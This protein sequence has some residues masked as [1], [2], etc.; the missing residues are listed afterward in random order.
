[1]HSTCLQPAAVHAGTFSACI[2]QQLSRIISPTQLRRQRCMPSRPLDVQKVKESERN[3]L[4]CERKSALVHLTLKKLK[5][6][7]PKHPRLYVCTLWVCA[8]GLYVM[9]FCVHKGKCPAE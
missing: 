9:Q 4:D 7:G 5:H 2:L 6:Y 3:L 1:M 8:S